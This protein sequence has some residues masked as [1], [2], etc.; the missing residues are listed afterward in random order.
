MRLEKGLNRYAYTSNTI[1][2][3]VIVD[4][5]M[6]LL[7]RSEPNIVLLRSSRHTSYEGEVTYKNLVRSRLM[8]H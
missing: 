1:C 3:L 4:S 8:L 5:P 7:V 2:M 6:M